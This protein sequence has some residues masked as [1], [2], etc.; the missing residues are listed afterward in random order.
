MQPFRKMVVLK[1]RGCTSLHSHQEGRRVLLPAHTL[2]YL[3]FVDFLMMM[4]I[5]TSVSWYLIVILFCI[6]L[7]S[8][9]VDHL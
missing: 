2:Q 1:H 3:Q 5:L 7:I 8:S 9:N 4:A 6:S